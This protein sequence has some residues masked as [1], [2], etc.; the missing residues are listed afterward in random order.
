MK[1]SYA[2]P[3]IE[4]AC[5]SV[6]TAAELF[7]GNRDLAVK[8]MSRINALKQADRIQDIMLDPSSGFRRTANR[9]GPDADSE[10]ELLFAISIRTQEEIWQILLQLLDEK[11]EPLAPYQFNL[12]DNDVT[13]R[14]LEITEVIRHHE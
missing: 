12:T 1:V 4:S 11:E 13:A 8:L 6:S 5:T 9:D 2:S 10:P 14:V 7:R 3:Q